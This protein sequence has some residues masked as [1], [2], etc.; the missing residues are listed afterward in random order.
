MAPAP[1]EP[2]AQTP[3]VLDMGATAESAIS[4]SGLILDRCGRCYGPDPSVHVQR[5]MARPEAIDALMCRAYVQTTR[6]IEGHNR[7][8][9]SIPGR[10][11]GRGEPQSR[12][13]HIGCVL[14]DERDTT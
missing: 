13:Q 8:S 4:A 10:A 11:V 6:S 3:N 1:G 14:L 2:L 7:P 12:A 9:R 5:T